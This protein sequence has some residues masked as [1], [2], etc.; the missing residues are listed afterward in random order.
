[1]EHWA[2]HTGCLITQVDNSIL[3]LSVAIV[4]TYL[5]PVYFLYSTRYGPRP[6]LR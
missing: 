5:V 6:L 2:T 3:C 4:Y 1:M